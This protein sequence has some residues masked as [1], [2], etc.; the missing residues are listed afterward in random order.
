MFGFQFGDE[1]AQVFGHLADRSLSIAFFDYPTP[2][3]MST[4]Q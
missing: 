1:T 2:R 3:M 4:W